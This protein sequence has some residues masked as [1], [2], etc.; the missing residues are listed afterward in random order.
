MPVIAVLFLLVLAILVPFDFATSVVPGW[1]TPIAAPGWHATIYPP[2]FLWVIMGAG[3][4]VFGLLAWW[5]RQ[6]ES[7]RTSW[8][9]FAGHCIL[10]LPAL[11]FLKCPTLWLNMNPASQET[12]FSALDLR[13]R[14]IPVARVVSLAANLFFIAYYVRTLKAQRKVAALRAFYN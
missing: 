2:Y 8:T 11:L 3:V 14:L 12:L 10:A 1:H 9:L 6:Y 13:I 4:L 5:L 7:D